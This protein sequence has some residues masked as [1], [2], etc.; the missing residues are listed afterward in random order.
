MTWPERIVKFNPFS[1]LATL[2]Q[3]TTL[4]K[5]FSWASGWGRTIWTCPTFLLVL[6]NRLYV[7]LDVGSHRIFFYLDSIGGKLTFKRQFNAYSWIMWGCFSFL[8]ALVKSFYSRVN[9]FIVESTISLDR[10]TFET[11]LNNSVVYN[12]CVYYR[13]LLNLFSMWLWK[14]RRRPVSVDFL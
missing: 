9:Y 4:C 1:V 11:C 5:A 8:M 12:H 2:K 6:K 13:L 10:A 14:W 3:R 7:D